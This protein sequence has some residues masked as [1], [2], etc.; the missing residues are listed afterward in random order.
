[1]T[2]LVLRLLLS[3]QF[4]EAYYARG[5]YPLLRRLL[6]AIHSLIPIHFLVFVI[7]GLLIW[8]MVK[9]LKVIKQKNT[10]SKFLGSLG[11][12][13]LSFLSL[14]FTLFTWLWGFNYGRVNIY[15]QLGIKGQAIPKDRM[16]AIAESQ[17][18]LII[19]LRQQT[20]S[21]PDSGET[22]KYV[23]PDQLKNSVVQATI[24]AFEE[25]NLG[26]PG[27]PIPKMLKPKGAL[28]CIS[29]AGFYSPWTGEPNIDAGLHP[30]QVPFVMAHELSHG[31]GVTDEGGCN[32]L[33][34]LIGRKLKDPILR[35]AFELSYWRYVM[36]SYRRQNEIAYKALRN[37]LPPNIA[38]DLHQ[39]R[40]NGD[41]YPDL[42][43]KLRNLFYDNYLK[44]QGV[45]AGMKSYGQV[46]NMVEAWESKE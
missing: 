31:M 22:P 33:A 1:M 6:D 42:F 3:Q 24:K 11:I 16:K 37:E 18:Q 5:L 28:L 4:I 43:P 45:K 15:D 8:I 13:T 35:Y 38:N 40:I 46:V 20:V 29:T 12:G 10:W 23:L 19:E 2:T 17:Q 9:T 39:I 30:L 7:L 21:L 41:Q 44:S 36:G 32:F 27:K 14:V 25:L 34:V 26:V